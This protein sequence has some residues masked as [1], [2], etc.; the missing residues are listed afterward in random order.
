MGKHLCLNEVSLGAYPYIMENFSFSQRSE[1]KGTMA[2]AV[3]LLR[4]LLCYGYI[5]NRLYRPSRTLSQASRLRTFGALTSIHNGYE[6]VNLN[7]AMTA[8][9]HA[10]AAADAGVLAEFLGRRTL[11]VGAAKYF[12]RLVER[13]ERQDGLWAG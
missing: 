5:Y 1:R 8:I 4:R 9:P 3:L 10:K 6:I 12:H 13:L 7:R 2:G 11:V